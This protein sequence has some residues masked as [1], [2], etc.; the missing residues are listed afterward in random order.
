M[1]PVCLLVTTGTNGAK[2]RIT[3][4]LNLCC[5]SLFIKPAQSNGAG[6][7]YV[8]NVDLDTGTLAGIIY[9][10]S[11]VSDYFAM[12]QSQN[13]LNQL[14]PCDFWI[15]GATTGDKFL[16]TYWVA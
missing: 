14:H 12:P 3:T 11:G 13:G 10:F 1:K 4:D 5:N 16:I 9:I 15:Q 8:G 2:V 6:P 7:Y